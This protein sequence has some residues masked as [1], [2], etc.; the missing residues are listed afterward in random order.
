MLVNR[1]GVSQIEIALYSRHNFS[2][3]VEDKREME[4]YYFKKQGHIA[5]NYI[6]QVNDVLNRKVK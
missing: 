3:S 5:W 1:E 4:C 2:R 6:F